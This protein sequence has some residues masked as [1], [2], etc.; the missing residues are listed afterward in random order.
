MSS[1]EELLGGQLTEA[2]E[3]LV[4]ERVAAALDEK[5]DARS[6]TSRWMTIRE[7]ADYLRISERQLHRL[8]TRGRVRT[9]TIGRRR[10]VH[11]D[12]LDALLRGGDAG[13]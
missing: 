1:L 12:E 5:C 7:A 9:S 6:S 8:L 4:D 10:L 13:R 11:R 2:L 3:R